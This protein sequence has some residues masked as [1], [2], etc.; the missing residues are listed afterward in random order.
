MKVDYAQLV[1]PPSLDLFYVPLY[2]FITL[3]DAYRRGPVFPQTQVRNVAARA[4]TPKDPCQ[5][6][7]C[8]K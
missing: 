7:S 4:V 1:S 2:I 6:T 5:R 3:T 8:S